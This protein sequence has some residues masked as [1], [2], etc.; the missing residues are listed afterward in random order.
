MIDGAAFEGRV[1]TVTGLEGELRR[2]VAMTGAC[3]D[4]A[5]IGDH[6]RHHFINDLGFHARFFSRL[7]QGTPRVAKLFGVGFNFF[8][9]QT[10]HGGGIIEQ[11][12]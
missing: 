9:N 11:V 10:L 12:L 2:I 3:T 4:P 7:D 8:D 5:F 1:Q 6:H